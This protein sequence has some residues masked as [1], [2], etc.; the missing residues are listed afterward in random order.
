M[1]FD[2]YMDTMDDAVQDIPALNHLSGEDAYRFYF[3]NMMIGLWYDYMSPT[4]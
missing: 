1:D 2:E 4:P 3:G